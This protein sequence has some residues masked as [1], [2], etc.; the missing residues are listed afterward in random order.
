VKWRD[1]MEAL[2]NMPKKKTN[3]KPGVAWMSQPISKGIIGCLACSHKCKIPFGRTG[4][5]GVRYD[6][7][8][9]LELLVYG[10]AAAQNVDPMEKKPLFH[11]YPGAEIFSFGTMGCNFRCLFCQNWD[12]SQFH[13]D[14][15]VDEIRKAGAP[16]SPQAIVDYCLGHQIP[17]V[18]FTYNEPGIFFEYAFDTA[19]LAKK[20]GLKTVYVS[21]GFESEEALDE[22]SPFIDAMNIDLKGATDEYYVKICGARIEPV[23]RNIERLWK[24]G[25][26]IEVTTLIEPSHNDDD[27]GLTEI[28]EFLA[29]VSSDMPWHLSRYFPC[30]RMADPPTPL[31]TLERAYEIG[32]KAGL[33]YVYV[34]N[35]MT[36]KHEDTACP[37]CG[38]LLIE[39]RGYS[40]QSRMAGNQCPKCGETIAGRFEKL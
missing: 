29:G 25:M 1:R 12:I 15:S 14:H 23:K 3:R 4:I 21:N 18:A 8:K 26:W 34:G 35:V 33:K 22:I 9:N 27:K 19:V 40:V 10:R 6:N 24:Q 39:R 28:A 32:K 16:L 5:C 37:K 38:E 30:Y 31:A 17:A 11:F 20:H 36:E 7:G 13:K 2:F